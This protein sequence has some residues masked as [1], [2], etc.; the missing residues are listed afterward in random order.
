MTGQAMLET[1]S[2]DPPMPKYQVK[3]PASLMLTSLKP[4]RT[5]MFKISKVTNEMHH[6]NYFVQRVV[7]F[8]YSFVY[9]GQDI[10]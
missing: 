7:V 9:I 1:P 4:Q 2:L 8:L 5:Y 6:G 3:M 10:L